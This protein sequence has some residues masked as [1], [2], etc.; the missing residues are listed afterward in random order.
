MEA[1]VRCRAELDA[2]M[3][4]IISS[5]FRNVYMTTSPSLGG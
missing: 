1:G 4:V 3:C 5:V 2:S